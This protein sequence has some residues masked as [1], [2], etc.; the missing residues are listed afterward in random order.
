VGLATDFAA[1]AGEQ[2]EIRVG[3]SH[4][5][6]DQAKK[7]LVREIPKWTFEAVKANARMVWNRAL[8]TILVKGGTERQRTIFYTAL[9]RT[10]CRMTDITEDGQYYSGH[11]HR[12]HSADGHD[13]YVDD[14]LW[15]TYRSAHPL[16]LLIETPRQMDM[17]RSYIR[18]YEQSGWMPSFPSIGGDRAVMI[19]HH[20]TALIADAYTKGYRDFDVEKAYAGMKKNAME[21]TMLPWRRGP[22]T[23]LDKVYLEKGFFPALAKGET[24]SVK[25]V[26]PSE[27]RQSVSVTLENCYD[28]WCLAQVAKGLGKEDD[29]GYFMKRARNYANLFNEWT[30][31]M[32]P[33]SA[34]GNWVDGPSSPNAIRG[35]TP[36][37]CS[38][39]RPA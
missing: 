37:T 1:S 27:H 16:S 13:F 18:M 6:V 36:G 30:G 17:V 31:F 20:S 33:K 21:S 34:D 9:Y 22:L 38:T 15:D 10:L 12:V 2:I 39:T 11:D 25:E 26:H 7:N 4:I 19:G 35:C 5:S 14:G 29:Y 3:I 8:S 28:D 23:E 24:E 32:A